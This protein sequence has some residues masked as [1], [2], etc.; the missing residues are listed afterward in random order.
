MHIDQSRQTQAALA[1]LGIPGGPLDGLLLGRIDLPADRCPHGVGG[2]TPVVIR[3][4]GAFDLLPYG[5]TVSDLL[6]R[7]D[8]PAIL[9]R[10][11]LH[12]VAQLPELMAASWHAVGRHDEQ[13]RTYRSGAVLA[14]T[15]HVS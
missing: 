9:R 4:E 2:P 15:M 12:Q 14:F 7:P 10:P 13:S 3:A 11:D 8:L 5:P 6:D 1:A